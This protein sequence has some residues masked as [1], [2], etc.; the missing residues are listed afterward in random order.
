MFE[1]TEFCQ[2][3][4]I[5]DIRRIEQT[6]DMQQ[7]RD[8]FDAVRNMSDD[9]LKRP[10]EMSVALFLD[11]DLKPIGYCIIG[12]GNASACIIDTRSILSCAVLLNSYNVILMH[13]HPPA[14]QTEF[15]P[16][17]QDVKVTK[18]MRYLL[19]Q[20]N[21]QLVDALVVEHDPESGQIICTSILERLVREENAEKPEEPKEEPLPAVAQPL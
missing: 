11:L 1:I 9:L 15:G 4:P 14:G 21:V 10:Y 6:A 3:E 16:S 7:I 8:R 12:Q 5:I 20:I 18:W 19:R 2:I 17:Q 13:T